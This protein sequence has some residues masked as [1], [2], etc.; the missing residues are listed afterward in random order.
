MSSTAN[1][2][3]HL[4]QQLSA[5]QIAEISTVMKTAAHVSK[6][7]DITDARRYELG[8]Q[9]TGGPAPDEVKLE[10]ASVNLLN[11]IMAEMGRDRDVVRATMIGRLGRMHGRL[12]QMDNKHPGVP[13]K[14][15][16]PRN[17]LNC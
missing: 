16:K 12:K 10:K 5:K 6:I 7:P 15:R 9:I 11:S 13:L 17:P 1:A 8:S 3:T 14:A 4:L 2:S